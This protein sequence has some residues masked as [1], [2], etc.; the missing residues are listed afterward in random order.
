MDNNDGGGL[1]GGRAGLTTAFLVL[2]D[3]TEGRTAL[4]VEM[5][6]SS[7]EAQES[8]QVTVTYWIVECLPGQWTVQRVSAGGACC[9]L[10]HTA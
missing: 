7:A 10:G 4:L 6:A 2:R 1:S 9:S 8:W 5:V 3:E